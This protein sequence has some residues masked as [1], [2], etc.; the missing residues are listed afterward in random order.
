MTATFT[1]Q[2]IL[3][4]LESNAAAGENATIRLFRAAIREQA[5]K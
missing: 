1:I 3:P 4:F 2:S 5:A